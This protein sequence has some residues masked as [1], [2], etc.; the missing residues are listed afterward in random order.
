MVSLMWKT[1]HFRQSSKCRTAGLGSACSLVILVFLYFSVQNR[2]GE[3]G[4]SCV[5]LGKPN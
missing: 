4:G 3:K 5:V 1:E 2:L